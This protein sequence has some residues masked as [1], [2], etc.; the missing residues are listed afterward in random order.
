MS[1]AH[2][3]PSQIAN[4][5]ES[6]DEM[7]ARLDL[8]RALEVV[9]I[10]IGALVGLFLILPSNV[11]AQAPQATAASVQAQVQTVAATQ[12]ATTEA[13]TSAEARKPV[14]VIPLWKTPDQSADAK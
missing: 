5:D 4:E 1:V 2:N 3:Y 12:N 8:R 13:Q 7:L 14:R 10:G 6:F 11:A 9:G